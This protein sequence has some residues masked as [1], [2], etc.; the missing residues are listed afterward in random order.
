MATPEPKVKHWY[1]TTTGRLLEVILILSSNGKPVKVRIRYL[2]GSVYVV[3]I[4]TWNFLGLKEYPLDEKIKECIEE[5]IN[6]GWD[7]K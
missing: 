3:G 1:A 2:D 5:N 7:G 6:G 4:K